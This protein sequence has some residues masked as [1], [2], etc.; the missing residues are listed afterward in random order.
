MSCRYAMMQV[1]GLEWQHWNGGRTPVQTA[2]HWHMTEAAWTFLRLRPHDDFAS[3]LPKLGEGGDRAGAM[4]VTITRRASLLKFD[5]SLV[6]PDGVQVVLPCAAPLKQLG[7]DAA[8]HAFHAFA[9]RQSGLD[10]GTGLTSTGVTACPLPCSSCGIC[11]R[12][13]LT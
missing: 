13:L 5:P 4:A 8:G 7:K 11:L 2:L 12:Q 3:A 6:P 9:R 1:Q 10:Q